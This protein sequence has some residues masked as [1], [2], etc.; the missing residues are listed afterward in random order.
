MAR[1]TVGEVEDRV[2]KLEAAADTTA[3]IR[4]QLELQ[5][6]VLAKVLCDHLGLESLA[7]QNAKKVEE[8]VSSPEAMAAGKLGSVVLLEGGR[9]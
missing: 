4:R 3:Y 1:A 9:V 7:G 2:S 8:L 6:G 5:V